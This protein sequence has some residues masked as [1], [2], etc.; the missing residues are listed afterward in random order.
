MNFQEFDKQYIKWY[1]APRMKGRNVLIAFIVIV[2]VIVG[3][4]LIKNRAKIAQ[5]VSPIATPSVQQQIKNKFNGL[6]IPQG[7]PSIDLKDVSGGSGMG[8]AT[9]SEV[10][11][12]LPDLAKGQIY[13]GY[14]ENSSGKT[15]LL[16]NLKSE[17]GGW[18]LNYDSSMYSGYNK[19]IVV[20]GTKHILEGSF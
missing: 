8:I 11:A 4:L 6:T 2:V 13:Q 10:L 9:R 7:E 17:K 3:V 1:F 12:D 18:I 16:G 20:V 19:V 14:L 15:V 5:K